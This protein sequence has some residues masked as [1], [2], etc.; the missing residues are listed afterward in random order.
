[1][2]TE[3]VKNFSHRGLNE[4][5]SNYS[6]REVGS[7]VGRSIAEN[8]MNGRLNIHTHVEFATEKYCALLNRNIEVMPFG[9]MP[10]KCAHT[11]YAAKSASGEQ[12]VSMLIRIIQDVQV[13][14]P[15]PV[16]VWPRTIARLKRIDDTDYCVRHS[17]EFTTLF[18]LIADGIV[19]DR[20]FIPFVGV[21]A[22][23][24]N[25]LPYEM[26]EGTSK[27][28][29]H[30]SNDDIDSIGHGR[31]LLEAADILSRCVIDIGVKGIGFEVLDGSQVPAKRLD[32][33]AGPV[34]FC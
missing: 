17:L 19:E 5:R 29:K 31:H 20:E 30:L 24:Q 18:S 14:E 23:G 10:S 1:M 15:P 4:H 8:Y 34:V 12:Q 11:K 32:V 3:S 25:E 16:V 28:I 9:D 21:V 26:V 7:N 2:G 6:N 33:L 22:L 13:P 27:V